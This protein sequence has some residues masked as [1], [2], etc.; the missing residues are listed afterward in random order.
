[1]SESCTW[2]HI[3]KIWHGVRAGQEIFKTTGY[4]LTHA[5]SGCS[6]EKPNGQRRTSNTSC[7]GFYGL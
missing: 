3:L 4:K 2:L 7:A 1:L 5:A 6:C